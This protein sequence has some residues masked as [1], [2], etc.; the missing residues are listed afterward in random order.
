MATSY[1]YVFVNH[2]GYQQFNFLLKIMFLFVNDQ[3][4]FVMF[5]Y[6]VLLASL[7]AIA[8]YIYIIQF[9][10]YPEEL[11]SSLM[12]GPSKKRRAT[13]FVWKQNMTEPLFHYLLQVIENG[14]RGNKYGLAA[15]HISEVYNVVVTTT[16]VSNHMRTWRAKWQCISRLKI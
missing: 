6:F 15:K 2:V 9:M 3:I 1:L 10:S 4:A 8:F 13:N 12:P 14:E 7:Y 5:N 16:N 11:I